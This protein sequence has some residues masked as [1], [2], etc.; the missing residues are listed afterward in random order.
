MRPKTITFN[1]I[2]LRDPKLKSVFERIINAGKAA[3]V[4]THFDH[5]AEIS[6][7]ARARIRELRE[8]GVQFLNQGVLLKGV[9]DDEPTLIRTF[10]NLHAIGLRPYYLFQ[11]RPV[12]G[13]SRFQVPLR[14]GVTLVRAAQHNL[15]GIQ[16]TFRYVMSH[17]TGKIEILGF[18]AKTDRL[19][20]RY[21]QA[22]DPNMV[23]LVFSKNCAADARWLDELTAV[24]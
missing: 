14:E 17:V 10:A 16:K 12:L 1:P 11:T 22:K 15:S 7:E 23:G 18:D 3:V 13:A 20:L 21:H 24:M 6:D 8:I 19:I 9:N 2:R 4:V 5:F